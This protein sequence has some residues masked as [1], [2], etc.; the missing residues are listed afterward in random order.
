MLQTFKNGQGSIILRVKLLNSSVSTG[1][2][3]TGL[4]NASSGL[5]I[6]TI[7]D[8]EATATVYTV[9]ASN[10]ETITT[11]GT[12]AAPTAG[13][14]R[15]KEVDATNHKGVYELQI[16]DARFAVSNAKSLLVSLSG[17]TNLAESDFVVQLQTVD[18]YVASGT[19]PV[20]V[21]Q[22]G[23]SNGTFASGRPEV[24]M[25]HIAGSAVSTSTAQ[26]GVNV[27]NFGGSAGTFASGIP[28]VNATQ[29]A[30]TA[31]ASADLSATM[32]TSVAT[33]ALTTQ[34]T[35]AYRANGAAPTVAQALCEILG[36]LGESSITSTTKTVKK[37]DHSTTAAT[38]TL[39]SATTPTSILRAT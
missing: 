2:G 25:T 23:G 21:T 19:L 28:A 31:Y 13:K 35:E 15:F 17:A 38:F 29:L 3:L 32:K 11:L 14:C 8:T 27:V 26:L 4:T 7:A 6:S 20:N 24:N 37:F 1:A 5:I 39:D 33:A 10:V 34:V 36:H 16:A 9:A 22:F 12:Y 18:P 30:G